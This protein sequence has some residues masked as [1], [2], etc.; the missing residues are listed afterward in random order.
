MAYAFDLDNANEESE[1]E[2]D[3]WVEDREGKTMLGMVPMAD[4][5]N[6][7]AEFNVRM[8]VGGLEQFPILTT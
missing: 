5:L 3:G 6:A 8:H 1:D 7:N 2:E 4:I